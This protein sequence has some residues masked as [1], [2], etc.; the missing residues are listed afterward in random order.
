MSSTPVRSKSTI[1]RTTDL[2]RRGKGVSECRVG[3]TIRKL[4]SSPAALCLEF[5]CPSVRL[6]ARCVPSKLRNLGVRSGD[7]LC[8]E[9]WNGSE[10]HDKVAQSIYKSSSNLSL[11]CPS[12]C[13]DPA[14]ASRRAAT[15]RL[16]QYR[17]LRAVCSFTLSLLNQLQLYWGEK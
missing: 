6:L 2:L 15:R 10:M 14:L 4:F 8:F 12:F 11:S 5:S 17:P 13:P 16:S 9:K 7:F 1:P 3:L